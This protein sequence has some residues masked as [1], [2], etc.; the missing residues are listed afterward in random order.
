MTHAAMIY[1]GQ[2]TDITFEPTT[3]EHGPTWTTDNPT[4]HLSSVGFLCHVT[5]QAYFGGTATVTCTYSDRIGSSSYTRTRRWTFTCADTKISVSPTSKSIKVGESFQISHSFNTTTY[6]NPSIQFTGY[7]NAVVSVSNNGVVTAKSA[8]TTQVYVKSNLGTNSAI[9]TVRVNSGSSGEST[10]SP[11]D[12]WDSTG[13]LTLTLDEAGKLSD[14][15]TE[16]N[17]YSIKNLTLI[18]LLNG[19]DLRLLRDMAGTDCNN[20]STNGKLEVLDLK[21]AVFVSGG[22]WYLHGWENIYNYTDDSPV[23]PKYSFRWCKSINKLRFPKYCTVVSNG[24]TLHCN[25]LV[26]LAIP[27]GTTEID[28]E[29]L[30][31]G[32][33]DFAMTS[34]TLPS[35]LE[36]FNASIYSCENLTDIYCYAVNPPVVKY[37]SSFKDFTNISNGTLYVPKGSAQAYWKAEGWRDFK[38]IKETLEVYNTLTIT[39]GENGCV[40]MGD[41]EIRQKYGVSYTGYQGFEIPSGNEVEIEIVP[42]EGYCISDITVNGQSQNLPTDNRLVLGSLSSP[43]RVSVNFEEGASVEDL[44]VDDANAKL[45]VYNMQG[46]LIKNNL[47]KDELTLLPAGLYIVKS[48]VRTYKIILR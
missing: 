7:D 17:K 39:V 18:G 13:T 5:A 37:P 22:P 16:S 19:A 8:G 9:C 48:D 31:G 14:Y 43:T 33:Q 40:K 1:P 45:S 4:L 11:Y 3:G 20:K 34:L 47:S 26:E 30:T 10:L 46:V 21:E 41:T 35:S 29:C 42:N 36:K 27:P 23:M 25:S 6:I 15:I 28:Q 44:F 24:G 38:D 2:T 12:R 32:W